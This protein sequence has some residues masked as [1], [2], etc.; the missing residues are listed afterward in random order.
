MHPPQLYSLL[1]IGGN[2]QQLLYNDIFSDLAEWR[3]SVYSKFSSAL[4]EHLSHSLKVSMDIMMSFLRRVINFLSLL[5]HYEENWILVT[6]LRVFG[7]LFLNSTWFLCGWFLEIWS[8]IFW[9]CLRKSEVTTLSQLPCEGTY[10]L[11]HIAS[12]N[13]QDSSLQA[14]FALWLQIPAY[15]S[16]LPDPNP[17]D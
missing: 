1:S 14:V 10:D 9:K 7:G 16:L 12:L 4:T 17:P 6:S 2:K 13:F 11:A 8:Y 5:C 15:A 3:S